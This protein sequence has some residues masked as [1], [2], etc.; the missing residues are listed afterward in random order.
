V[1]PKLR[2]YLVHTKPAAEASAQLNLERQGYTAYL[3]RALQ[4]IRHRGIWRERAAPLFPRYLFLGLKTGA[5]SLAPVRSSVA[6]AGVVRFGAEYAVVPDAVIEQLYRRTDASSGLLRIG[7]A[8]SLAP[9]AAVRI[10]SGPLDGLEGI[11]ERE[12][13]M[14]RV[15]VLLNLLGADAAVQVPARYVVARRAA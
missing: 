15:V 3:P 13:G 10:T 12:E 14:E 2:W 8:P 6:V 4:A 1:I 11:F 9:G 7:M 5:Q